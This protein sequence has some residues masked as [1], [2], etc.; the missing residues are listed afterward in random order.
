MGRKLN[1]LGGVG[2]G[3]FLSYLLD[4]DRGR[5]R[6]ALARDKAARLW[7]RGG[8]WAGGVSRDM[9]NRARGLVTQLQGRREEAPVDEDVLVA[10]VRSEIGRVVSHPR[11]IEVTASAGRVTL[12]GPILTREVEDLLSCVCSVRGVKGVDNRLE[13]HDE[14][15]N[16][17]GLQGEPS[18]GQD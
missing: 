13:V 7:S 4:P 5:R 16:V 12:S 8:R 10:R 6:R 1:L 14:P 18:R 2:I 17:P 11:A 3:A 15:G 9:G